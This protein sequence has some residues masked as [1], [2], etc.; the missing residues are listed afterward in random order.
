MNHKMNENQPGTAMHRQSTQGERDAKALH[1]TTL[2]RDVTVDYILEEEDGATRAAFGSAC[3][4]IY[5]LRIRLHG[6]AGDEECVLPD[7]ARTAEQAENM[8]FAF[9]NGGVMPS[10]AMEVAEEWLS[11]H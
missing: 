2:L 6:P 8:L 10:S 1:R 7:V 4:V 11:T 9:A 3:P 5:S